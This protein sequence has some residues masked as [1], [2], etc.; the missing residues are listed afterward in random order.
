ME[1]VLFLDGGVLTNL[2]LS[3]RAHDILSASLLPCVAT[4]DILAEPIG[5]PDR[6]REML[7]LG[8]AYS[9]L[10]LGV[11]SIDIHDLEERFLEWAMRLPAHLAR[12][13]TYCEYHGHG[14]ATDD[15]CLR[16]EIHLLHAPLAVLST[17]DFVH[18]WF[19]QGTWS[20]YEV[21][22]T[23]AAIEEQALYS[24]ENGSLAAEWWHRTVRKEDP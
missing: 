4:P 13:L 7:S 19:Q 12:V 10:P 14:L 20:E 15:S 21:A 11:H 24:P 3:G 8:D 23:L 1:R 22:S 6:G 5:H 18:R 2:L 16:Q 9:A 17:A